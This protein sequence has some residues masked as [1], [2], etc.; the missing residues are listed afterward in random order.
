MGSGERATLHVWRQGVLWVGIG[1]TTILVV[2]GLWTLVSRVWAASFTQTLE[3]LVA[4]PFL[5]GWALSPL[6]WAARPR[7]DPEHRDGREDEVV[8]LVVVVLMVAVGALVYVSE[9]FVRPMAFGAQPNGRTLA[10]VL[11]APAVQ[12]VI[13]GLGALLLVFRRP[14]RSDDPPAS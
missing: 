1:V 5:A 7:R 3:I 11:A 6:L 9:L 10:L 14:S 8:S 4:S 12:W 13:M 2:F